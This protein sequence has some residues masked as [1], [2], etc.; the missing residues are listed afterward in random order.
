MNSNASGGA[1]GASRPDKGG[2]IVVGPDE[3]ESWWQPGP[4]NGYVTVK[5]T[6]LN[7]PSNNLSCGIQVIDPG[8]SLREH[9]HQRNEELLFVFE[10]RGTAVVDGQHHPVEPGSLIYAGR[11]TRHGLVNDGDGPM[12]ILWIFL[13][14]GLEEVLASLGAPRRPGDARP[15]HLERPADVLEIL[16]RGWFA[17]PDA[18]PTA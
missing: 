15:Q 13:P 8:C 17:P 18:T 2:A 1:A 9:A 5:L 14:P 12:K 6:P 7:C 4:S 16:A 10:G 11:W 3:G